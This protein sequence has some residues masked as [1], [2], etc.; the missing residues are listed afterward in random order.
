MVAHLLSLTSSGQRIVPSDH[1]LSFIEY[2]IMLS[3]G[4]A[5]NNPPKVSSL[6]PI[7]QDPECMYDVSGRTSQVQVIRLKQRKALEVSAALSSTFSLFMPIMYTLL[8]YIG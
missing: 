5:P 8:A 2:I 3:L 6:G 7:R 4:R 1:F